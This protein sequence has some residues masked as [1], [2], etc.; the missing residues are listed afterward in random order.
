MVLRTTVKGELMDPLLTLKLIELRHQELRADAARARRPAGA[1]RATYR[2]SFIGW[3]RSI[4]NGRR[5]SR[6]APVQPAR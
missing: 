4:A 2:Q 6:T 1:K 5:S 3:L